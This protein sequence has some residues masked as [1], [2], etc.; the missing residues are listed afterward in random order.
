MSSLDAECS[1]EASENYIQFLEQ[2]NGSKKTAEAQRAQKLE[3]QKLTE[4][5]QAQMKLDPSKLASMLREAG[6]DS[7]SL[8]TAMRLMSDQEVSGTDS[9]ALV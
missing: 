2:A 7:A 1:A 8:S 3:V 5:S 9:D 6:W 4:A